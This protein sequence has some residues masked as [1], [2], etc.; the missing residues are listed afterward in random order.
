MTAG[1]CD[2]N[3]KESHKGCKKTLDK[4]CVVCYILLNTPESLS[5][6]EVTS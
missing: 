5:D 3:N 2:I 4:A 6:M 1:C